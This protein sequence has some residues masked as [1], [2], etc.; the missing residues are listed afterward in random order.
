[1]SCIRMEATTRL[2]LATIGAAFALAAAPLS[3]EPAEIARITSGPFAVG[4]TNFEVTVPEG[5]NLTQYL[6]GS[7]T[8]TEE[9]SIV[10]LLAHPTDA[11][12]VHIDVPNDAVYGRQAGKTVDLGAVVLYPTTADN[13]RADFTFPLGGADAVLPHMQGAG[14]APVFA[15]PQARYPLVIYSHG[16]PTNGM[17]DLA[18]LKLLASQ[19]FIVACVQHGDNANN[20]NGCLGMRPLAVSGLVDTLLAHPQFGPMIDADRIGMCGWS[21]GGYTTLATVG[22]GIAGHPDMGVETRFRAAFAIMPYIGSAGSPSFGAGNAQMASIDKPVF[23]IY[24]STDSTSPKALTEAAAAV[25]AGSTSAVELVGQGHTPSADGWAETLTY[26]ILFF[27]AWLQDDTEALRSLYSEMHIEGDIED[28]RTIQRNSPI[29]AGLIKDGPCV[30]TAGWLGWLYPVGDW[31]WSY[32]LDAWVYLPESAVEDHG[33]WL[34]RAG[35]Q[36]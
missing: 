4:S 11:V 12:V 29:W 34:Y 17:G 19:G 20:Y 16:Y 22:A 9:R 6:N 32:S 30:E 23:I 2:T 5:V 13:A 24:G 21:M 10:N 36:G 28:Q 33:G 15:D 35:T 18:R 26:Q 31:V 14:E 7:Y 25:P 8:A 27:K 3:A 1:V